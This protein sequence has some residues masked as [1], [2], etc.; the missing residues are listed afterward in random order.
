MLYAFAAALV[1]SLVGFA[2]PRP[3]A[4]GFAD[5]PRI[6]L[7][8]DVDG[9][10]R[11][12]LIAVY[13]QGDCI[14]DVNLTREGAKSSGGFHAITNWGK[15]CQAATAGDIEGTHKTDVVG[16]FGKKLRLAGAF[17]DGHYKDFPD[18]A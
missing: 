11:A 4:L 13:P 15:D 12:D 2:P 1:P 8:G 16:L 3:W 17:A 10:G 18:W 9:D 7:V 6:P 5:A 14:I